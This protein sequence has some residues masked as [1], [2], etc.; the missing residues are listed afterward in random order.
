M[1]EPRCPVASRDSLRGLLSTPIIR[2][3]KGETKPAATPAFSIS[4]GNPGRGAEH[5][6]LSIVCMCLR[7]ASTRQPENRRG[8]APP[9]RLAGLE[10][11]EE[12]L[13]ARGWVKRCRARGGKEKL[14]GRKRLGCVICHGR[15]DLT[16]PSADGTRAVRVGGGWWVLCGG[17][18]IWAGDTVHT[19]KGAYP[20]LANTST[21][22]P[23]STPP[24]RL[25]I[26][27]RLLTSL[28]VADYAF[29]VQTH[30]LSR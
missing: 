29:L 8:E 11:M 14:T 10:M 28:A 17:R 19:G 30:G 1:R 5:G 22:R 12:S 23:P 7:L 26:R 27:L 6:G 2:S 15:S 25:A 13:A 3:R 21:I 20:S 4:T 16:R 24:G 9:A 18:H